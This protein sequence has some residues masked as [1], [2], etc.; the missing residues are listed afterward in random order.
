MCVGELRRQKSRA[1]DH[2]LSVREERKREGEGGRKEERRKEER[3][4]W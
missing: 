4:A 2:S 3:I 1:R